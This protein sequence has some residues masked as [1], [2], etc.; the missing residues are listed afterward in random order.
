MSKAFKPGDL[1]MVK[2]CKSAPGLVG[3]C[4]ELV[5]PAEPGVLFEFSGMYWQAGSKRSWI[6]TGENLVRRT[7]DGEMHESKLTM[8]REDSLMPLRDDDLPAETLDTAA[9]RELVSA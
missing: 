1:A 5:M 7:G 2:I 8:F 3:K 6:V 4:V 9:P